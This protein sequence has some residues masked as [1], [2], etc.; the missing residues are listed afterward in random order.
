MPLYLAV[1]DKGA[2]VH[3]KTLQN[4][5]KIHFRLDRQLRSDH[6]WQPE[7]LQLFTAM[8]TV[9]TCGAI[10]LSRQIAG[11]GFWLPVLL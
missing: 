5:E 4:Y 6:W 8:F 10:D 9:L 7:F 1:D 2:I 11:A 3:F